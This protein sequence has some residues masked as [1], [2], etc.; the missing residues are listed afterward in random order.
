MTDDDRN[1]WRWLSEELAAEADQ[2]RDSGGRLPSRPVCLSE[3]EA[4]GLL[5]L[6]CDAPEHDAADGVAAGAA[7]RLVDTL[8]NHLTLL[9]TNHNGGRPERPPERFGNDS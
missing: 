3:V 2:A 4:V 5:M 8:E 1:V 6:A 7:R 9:G